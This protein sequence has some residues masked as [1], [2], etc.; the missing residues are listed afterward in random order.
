MNRKKYTQEFR[1]S[2]VQLALDTEKSITDIA[3]DL[4]VNE[5]TLH[6]WITK[7]K[8]AKGIE[9]PS[10]NILRSST[11]KESETE[12][13]ARLRKEVRQLKQEREILKKAAA[14]FARETV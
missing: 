1:D 13:L 12:E 7:Y 4:D 10:R 3:I 6:N 5:S 11:L 14:Y 8:K 9:I 2:C